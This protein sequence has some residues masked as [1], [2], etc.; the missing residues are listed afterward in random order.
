MTTD[1]LI[2]EELK[3]INSNIT[4][5]REQSQIQH[6]EWRNH[7][8]DVHKNPP[9]LSKIF[10]NAPDLKDM[11]KMASALGGDYMKEKKEWD[12]KLDK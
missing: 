3:K 7:V 10:D 11:M 9:D 5:L 4:A 1:E 12:E 6:E 2:L 8:D